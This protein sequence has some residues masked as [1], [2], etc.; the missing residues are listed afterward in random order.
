MRTGGGA[1]VGAPRG[2]ASS[3]PQ[4]E[5]APRAPVGYG[6]PR[7][8]ARGGGGASGCDERGLCTR[9]RPCTSRSASPA[10][11]RGARCAAAGG[12]RAPPSTREV[13]EV[14]GRGP[15][16][17]DLS[18][19]FPRVVFCVNEAGSRGPGF[20]SLTHTHTFG[21]APRLFNPRGRTCPPPPQT[22]SSA[23]LGSVR[24]SPF[25]SPFPPPPWGFGFRGGRRGFSSSDSHQVSCPQGGFGCPLWQEVG[26][27]APA[28]R[29][30]W[31]GC[32]VSR[33]CRPCAPPPSP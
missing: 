18:L 17:R 20:R 2:A 15:V 13:L 23:L 21:P 9:R 29:C 19:A 11:G 5:G 7:G 12:G 33:A 28:W 16:P 32:A 6:D 30:M 14:R 22:G 31:S 3:G 8:T 10:S 25:D 4:A 1:G 27:G 26:P 24:T